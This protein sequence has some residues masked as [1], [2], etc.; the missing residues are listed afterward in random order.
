MGE[1]RT[2]K[3]LVVETCVA[4][5][6]VPSFEKLT[7]L[8]RKYFP[9]SKWQKTHYA[10][11][12][13][14]I[15]TGDIEVPGIIG[16]RQQEPTGAEIETEL[17]EVVEASVSLE[18]DLHL[19]YASRVS[20]LEPGLTLVSEGVEYQTDA[21]RID[22]LARDT[23]GHLVV[24]ELKAG[25]AKDGALGQ[26]LGYIGCL[27]DSMTNIRGILVASEFDTR[28]VFAAKALPTVK[29]HESMNAS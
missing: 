23:H 9:N 13:S 20:E 21:G 29:L 25:K 2:I 8:V 10:W 17:E 7:S 14:K 24:I 3:D 12:K 16:E 18:R 15:K 6:G 4:E 5:G 1:Y 26:L 27:A 19:D 22:L 28:V 11:Y